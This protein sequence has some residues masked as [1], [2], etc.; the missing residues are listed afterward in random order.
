[1]GKGD[2]LTNG[3]VGA[4]FAFLFQFVPVVGFLAPAAG[5]WLAGHLQKGDAGGGLKAGLAA[6]IFLLVPNLLLAGAV[7][8]F[9][10]VMGAA[11]GDPTGL[12]GGAVLGVGLGAVAFLGV[13]L[14]VVGLAVVGGVVGGAIAGTGG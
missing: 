5:G 6:G 1:M 11:S 3:I 12:L 4:L 8:L 13:G 2:T 14:Y 9:F 10:T 7:F